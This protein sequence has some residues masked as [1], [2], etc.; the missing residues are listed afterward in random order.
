MQVLSGHSLDSQ[1]IYIVVSNLSTNNSCT[2][3]STRIFLA[4]ISHICSIRAM[5][6][7]SSRGSWRCLFQH[8]VD[9]LKGKA[10]RLGDKDIGVNKAKKAERAPEE[11]N[12]G[13]KVGIT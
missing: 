8:A 12:F 4:N 9:L 2:S 13:A 7:P 10:F 3:T 6:D 11:E 5:R 1:V